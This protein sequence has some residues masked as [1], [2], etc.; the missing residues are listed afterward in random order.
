MGQIGALRHVSPTAPWF[1]AAFGWEATH[2]LML[3][4]QGDVAVASTS[5]AS[6]PPDPRGYALWAVSAAG[7]FG[8]EPV[9]DVGL[10]VQGELGMARATEDVLSTYGFKEANH[11]GPYY[12]AL[13]GVEWFQVSPHYAL[14]LQGGVRYYGQILDRSLGNDPALAWIGAAALRYTF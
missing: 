3:L 8:I 7:R 4:A 1:H 13:L 10:Y 6:P 9:E 14:A 5:L 12:G 11:L 2:W